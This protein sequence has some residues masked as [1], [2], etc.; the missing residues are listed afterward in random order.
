MTAVI[1]ITSSAAVFF[2]GFVAY[3]VAS[4]MRPASDRLQKF[5]VVIAWTGAFLFAASIVQVLTGMGQ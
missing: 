2:V 1:T 5:A 4:S 3:C